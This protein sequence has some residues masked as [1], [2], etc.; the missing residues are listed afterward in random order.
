[1]S[2]IGEQAPFREENSL[3]EPRRGGYLSMLCFDEGIDYNKEHLTNTL[4]NILLVLPLVCSPKLGECVSLVSLSDGKKITSWIDKTKHSEISHYTS[5]I[6]AIL[7]V[8][9][10][11]FR[12]CGLVYVDRYV[13][14]VEPRQWQKNSTCGSARSRRQTDQEQHVLFQ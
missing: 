4:H 1:M 11:L 2:Y 6:V 3:I 12:S 7:A 10:H 8:S 5:E 13:G 14:G 9:T